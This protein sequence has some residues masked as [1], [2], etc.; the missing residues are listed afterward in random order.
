MFQ[1]FYACLLKLLLLIKMLTFKFKELNTYN[2]FRK[3]KLLLFVSLFYMLCNLIVLFLIFLLKS[4]D[5]VIFSYLLIFQIYV[6]TKYLLFMQN[7]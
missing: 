6:F 4:I 3:I 7:L 5:C 2:H 1:K